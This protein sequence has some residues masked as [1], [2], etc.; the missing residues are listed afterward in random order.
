MLVQRRVV[1]LQVPVRPGV[2]LEVPVEE[3]K[4]AHLGVS[5]GLPCAGRQT[6]LSCSGQEVQDVVVT[7]MPKDL[8]SVPVGQVV[9]G[10]GECRS[11]VPLM[12]YGKLR[13]GPGSYNAA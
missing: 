8:L 12:V 6:T 10:K 7:G 4:R 9:V 3:L 1:L 11:L 5:Q 2:V 13:K